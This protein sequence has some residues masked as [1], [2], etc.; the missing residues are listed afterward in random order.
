MLSL[1][2]WLGPPHLFHTLIP[3]SHLPSFSPWLLQ[4]SC[5]LPTSCLLVDP[6]R[7]RDGGGV[8]GSFL[9][10]IKWI[11]L[12]HINTLAAAGTNPPLQMSL[13]ISLS[14]QSFVILLCDRIFLLV[15]GSPPPS[16]SSFS[17]L[18]SAVWCFRASK[19]KNLHFYPMLSLLCSSL[20][21]SLQPAQLIFGTLVHFLLFYVWKMIILHAYFTE[22]KHPWLGLYQHLNI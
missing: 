4:N 1:Q 9:Y 13:L 14:W 20:P 12:L 2:L 15:Y 17:S 7:S 11:H 8:L 21:P 22:K 5:Y 3:A 6:P 10:C 18:L 16:L 19:K